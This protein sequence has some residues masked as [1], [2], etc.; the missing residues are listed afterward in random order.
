MKIFIVTLE[1]S[2]STTIL[3]VFSSRELADKYCLT[4]PTHP[5][6]IVRVIEQKVRDL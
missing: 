1:D 2:V 3:R 4:I 6:E 5:D